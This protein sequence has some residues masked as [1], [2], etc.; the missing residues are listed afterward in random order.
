MLLWLHWKSPETHTTLT[1]LV[2]L[3]A[4][5]H[6]LAK[7][8]VIT[9]KGHGPHPPIMEALSQNY[10]PPKSLRPSAKAIPSL[11]VQ[12]PDI[13]P[14]KALFV[15]DKLPDGSMFPPVSIALV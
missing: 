5:G 12:L 11:W 13:Q 1:S 2:P 8:Q 10:S 4:K 14:A 15:K 3:K 9:K 6:I 7:C